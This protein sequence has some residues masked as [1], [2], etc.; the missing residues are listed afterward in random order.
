MHFVCYLVCSL[1]SWLNSNCLICK[2]S[3]LPSLHDPVTV[4]LRVHNLT[5]HPHEGEK[6]SSQWIFQFMQLEIRSLKKIQA[7]TGFEPVT[8]A[9]PL[10][11]SIWLRFWTVQIFV[12]EER[13]WCKY[14]TRRGSLEARVVTIR[15]KKIAA[16]LL[17]NIRRPAPFKALFSL[18]PC[19]LQ[20]HWFLG[21]GNIVLLCVLLPSRPTM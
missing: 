13:L 14:G 8:S 10:P 11:S 17:E 15:M 12:E 20:L 4:L 3:Q 6:W 16:K 5:N 19:N 1:S 2:Y 18:D 7:S 21:L 9:L